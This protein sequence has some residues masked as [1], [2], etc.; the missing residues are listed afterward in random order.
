M[1]VDPN[2][3]DKALEIKKEKKDKKYQEEEISE[4]EKNKIKPH[5]EE[6]AFAPNAHGSGFI[7]GNGKFV[8]TNFHVMRC[9][10][11]AVRNGIGKVTES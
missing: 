1:S 3:F 6:F 11:I 2:Y 8:I 10:R 7:V 5:Y 4:Y 9:K